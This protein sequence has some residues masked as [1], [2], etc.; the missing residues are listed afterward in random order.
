MIRRFSPYPAFA[1]HN[2]TDRAST[3]NVICTARC[4]ILVFLLVLSTALAHA[5]FDTAEVLG[6]IKDPSGASI[7]GASVAL[8]DLARGIKVSRQT[9][10]NGNYDFTNVQVGD[11]SLSVTAPGFE[12]S[13]TDRFTVDR[14]SVV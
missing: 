11:Y 3:R 7:S 13:V 14:K 9:D 4:A 2:D 12:T 8:T 1:S 6:I 5:Q 10:A